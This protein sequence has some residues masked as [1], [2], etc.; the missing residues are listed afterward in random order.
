[1]R[2]LPSDLQKKQKEYDEKKSVRKHISDNIAKGDATIDKLTAQSVELERE[3]IAYEKADAEFRE[4]VQ[5]KA[6]AMLP[7]GMTLNLFRPLVSAT[8]HFT[9]GRIFVWLA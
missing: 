3:Q 1:M 4:A 9:P 2:F 5:S 7:E 6:N 8:Y